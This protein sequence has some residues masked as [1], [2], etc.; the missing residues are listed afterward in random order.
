MAQNNHELLELLRFELK[1][2]EDGGYGRSPRTPW[3]SSLVFEDSLTCLNFDDQ[4]RPHPCS[5]C[6]LMRFVPA[7]LRDHKLPCRLI[8]LDAP[9]RTLDHL[10]RY[11]TQAELEAVSTQ[12]VRNKIKEI[13]E[14]GVTEE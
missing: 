6:L 13:E 2:M 14:H 5:E 8:P 11:G 3:R 7:E 4:S 9:G 1:F 12:W 10:Y